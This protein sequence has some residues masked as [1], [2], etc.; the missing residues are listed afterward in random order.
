MKFNG[1]GQNAG[2]AEGYCSTCPPGRRYQVS[3]TDAVKLVRFPAVQDGST[4]R[5]VFPFEFYL[6]IIFKTF[7]LAYPLPWF[8]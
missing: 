7:P 4:F 2:S 5:T 6:K 3:E 1:R 8:R